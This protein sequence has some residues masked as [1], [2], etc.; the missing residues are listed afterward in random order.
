MQR[1]SFGAV[2][3]ALGVIIILT[4]TTP[5]AAAG[6]CVWSCQQ[7]PSGSWSYWFARNLSDCPVTDCL[8]RNGSSPSGTPCDPGDPDIPGDCRQ[9]VGIGKDEVDPLFGGDAS[10]R[11]V[12]AAPCAGAK[13][14]QNPQ[15]TPDHRMAWWPDLCGACSESAECVGLLV[16]DIRPCK[17]EDGG[18]G[19]CRSDGWESCTDTDPDDNRDEVSCYCS[20]W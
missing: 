3:A 11:S 18:Q 6:I 16:L 20:D 8:P 12:P 17:T 5:A 9:K 14:L 19:I 1:L 4:T 2:L 13:A 7:N 10:S 15:T